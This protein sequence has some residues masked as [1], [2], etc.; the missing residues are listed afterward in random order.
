MDYTTPVAA[1]STAAH[2]KRST[3]RQS[4]NRSIRTIEQFPKSVVSCQRSMRAS[5][6]SLIPSS[7]VPF[8]FISRHH[9]STFSVHGVRP[10]R[11]SRRAQRP[12][13][14][15]SDSL[16]LFLSFIK[17]F[18][19][20]WQTDDGFFSMPTCNRRTKCGIMQP[21]WMALRVILGVKRSD[22]PVV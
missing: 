1:I 21:T 10:H 8:S 19:D 15:Q 9:L 18:H 14:N 5:R 22:L 20:R 3:I 16:H 11:G 2:P 7:P 6:R 17:S 12:G 13:N 4:N